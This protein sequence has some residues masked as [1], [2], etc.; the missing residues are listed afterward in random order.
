MEIKMNVYLNFGEGW[1]GGMNAQLKIMNGTCIPA[2]TPDIH[3]LRPHPGQQEV[4]LRFR[5]LLDS[6]HHPS[7]I[8]GEFPAMRFVFTNIQCPCLPEWCLL[9]R[10]PQVLWPCSGC[11]HYAMLSSGKVTLI[12]VLA[13]VHSITWWEPLWG[14]VFSVVPEY[15]VW[16]SFLT[17]VS[18]GRDEASKPTVNWI[19]CHKS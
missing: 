19:M 15:S 10:E 11:L 13:G 14:L 4:A 1:G 8:A 9:Y 17:S 7:E 16:F 12:I 2:T 18:E 3:K 5:S 6:D